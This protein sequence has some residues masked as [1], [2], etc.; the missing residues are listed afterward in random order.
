MEGNN[1]L[2]EIDIKNRTWYY[3]DDIIKVEY[4]DFKNILINDKS[5]ENILVYDIN[6][7]YQISIIN[8]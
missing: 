3:L 4:F 6:T 7:K 5:F 1:K 2:K 8:I